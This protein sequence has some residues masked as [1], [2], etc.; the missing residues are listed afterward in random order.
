MP[1]ISESS[2]A[3]LLTAFSRRVG[4]AVLLFSL[5]V[6]APAADPSPALDAARQAEQQRLEGLYRTNRTRLD[7]T[8]SD[9]QALL[10]FSRACFD[11]AEFATNNANRASLAEAGTGADRLA[12]TQAPTNGL[13]HY[14][15]GLNLGQLARTR[16]LSGLK[17]VG[18]ME[19]AW[20]KAI[21]LDARCDHAGPHRLLG[22]LYQGAPGWPVSVGN[23]KAAR[24]Q[25]AK[26]TEVAPDYPD[27]WLCRIEALIEWDDLKTARQLLPQ[28]SPVLAQTAQH[29]AGAEWAWQRQDWEQRWRAIQ[30]RLDTAAN[31][32]T[33]TGGQ[34]R[35]KA[36]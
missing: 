2:R 34:A 17:L 8:P 33:E 18:Q 36:H 24:V 7:A 35:I 27:N 28:A 31:R 12:L 20:L 4:L 26:A 22:L 11:L 16:Y 19:A 1:P 29:F 13:A 30:A 32:S 5:A 3:R 14:Y 21:A 25:F 6:H 15:L 10:Q 23:R 9:T